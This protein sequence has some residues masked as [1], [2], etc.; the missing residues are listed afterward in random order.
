M[1]V[2]GMV[3]SAH[4][5]ASLAGVRMLMDGGNAF[6]AAVAT[7]ATLNVAEPYMSGIGGIGLALAYVA[8]ENRVRAPAMR[9][10]AV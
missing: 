2:N 6:D 5:L 10:W 7:A 8:A 3:A 4:P 9:P 1:G